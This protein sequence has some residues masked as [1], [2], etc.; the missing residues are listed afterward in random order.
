MQL[1]H[2]Y[3]VITLFPA[4][5]DALTQFG[6]VG[7]A[8][9][10][11]K[12]CVRCWN[13]WDYK[14]DREHRVDDAPFGGGTS[15]VMKPGP[16]VR[17]VRA[18]QSAQDQQGYCAPHVLYLSP[19]GTPLCRETVLRLAQYQSLILLCGRYEG[20]DERVISSCV[21]QEISVGD[22]VTS[23]GEIPAMMVLDT[24]IRLLPG[25]VHRERTTHHESF[26][27]DLLDW[28]CYTRPAIF[29]GQS[30]PPVLL[31]GHHQH[32]QHWRFAQAL[33]LTQHRRPDLWKK[34]KKNC[35]QQNVFIEN[36]QDS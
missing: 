17:A 32:I 3:D 25:V 10:Q 35:I 33:K 20:I 18:A 13:P 26:L 29:E 7:R 21:D 1:P 23:G 15:L 4:M 9:R 27:D 19:R 5:F 11:E 2:R 34:R 6:V 36:H 24:V 22:F 31:S 14:A 30:V 8:C 16:I 12:C 28:P